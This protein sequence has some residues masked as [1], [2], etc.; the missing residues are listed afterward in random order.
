M[1]AA[2]FHC[3]CMAMVR[4]TGKGEGMRMQVY[5]AQT[6][7]IQD[8]EQFAFYY[9]LLHPERRKKV[10]RM[11]MAKDKELSLLAGL[12]LREGLIQNGIS[13]EDAKVAYGPYG[14][15]F[16]KGMEEQFQFN[17]SHSGTHVMGIFDRQPVG[18]DVQKTA[19]WNERG[20]QKNV[21]KR[22]FHKEEYEAILSLEEEKQQLLFYRIWTLKE[23]FL[24]VCGMGM[25][26]ECNSFSVMEVIREAMRNNKVDEPD[27]REPVLL[28]HPVTDEPFYMREYF[29]DDGYCYACSSKSH[30]FPEKMQILS[31]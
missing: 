25:K 21:A 22:F 27:D 16:V 7:F 11:R 31:F 5:L 12:V 20:T 28:V 13:Y 3:L 23:S 30:L 19:V 17:L 1:S 29:R 18:C 10:D 6:D 26:L 4:V 15:P 14:K 8:Q 24:K 2:L 9:S